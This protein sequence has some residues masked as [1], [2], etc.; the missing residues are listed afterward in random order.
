MSADNSKK[1]NQTGN[2]K[3]RINQVFAL[4]WLVV[5]VIFIIQS[6]GLEYMAEY[7]PGPGFLPF[8]LGVGFILLGLV[9]LAQVT[10]SRKEKEDLSLPSKYAAWQ[11]FLVMLGFF[12]FV[13]LGEKVGFL[14]CIGLLFFFLL[15]FVERR[16]WKFSLAIS[17]ISTFLFWA[18]FEL[19]LQLRLPPGLLEL[20]R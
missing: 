4:L 6:R 5:G 12:G 7:G 19:G 13:F 10:F 8:W 3:Q 11:M 2:R 17:I 9:L 1:V 20:L 18:I 16:G 15:G 14:F